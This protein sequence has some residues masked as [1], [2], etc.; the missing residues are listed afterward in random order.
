MKSTFDLLWLIPAVCGVVLFWLFALKLLIRGI[1]G[2]LSE[3]MQ[4]LV[5]LWAEVKA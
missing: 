2:M 5:D 3:I 4:V 1:H